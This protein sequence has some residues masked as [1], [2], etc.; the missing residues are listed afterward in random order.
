[1]PTSGQILVNG[2]NLNEIDTQYWRSKVGYMG[3]DVQHLFL[4][5]KENIEIGDL[6]VN[7]KA[8]ESERL[9]KAIELAG[10]QQDVETL[11]HKE[12][13]M[14]GKYFKGGIDFSGGQWQ[15]LS[16]ARSLYR[17]SPLIILDE[18]TSSVDS[19]TERK[20]INNLVQGSFD[21]TLLIVSHKFSNINLADKIYVIDD[22]KVVE[23]GDHKDLMKLN[24]LYA[25]LY[26]E[27]EKAYIK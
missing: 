18:P 23:S 21:K 8:G 17:E 9:G 12:N 14:L 26:S 16:L 15:K 24:K 22:G 27:Q 7:E 25:K 3:Q 10:L 5:V 20:I 4:T 11:P 1:V 19:T 2:V 6:N 13:N